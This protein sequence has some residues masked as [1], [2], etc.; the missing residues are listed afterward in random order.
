MVGRSLPL[1]IFC[2][3]VLLVG[4]AAVCVPLYFAVVAGS[5]S[6]QEVQ[7]TSFPLLPDEEVTAPLTTQPSNH[8]PQ[9]LF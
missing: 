9:R 1:S 6:L 4:A 7:Q 2:H 5:L 8:R 3:A